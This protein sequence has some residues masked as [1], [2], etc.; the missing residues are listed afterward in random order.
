MFG[1]PLSFASVLLYSCFLM[2]GSIVP[3]FQ[4][5]IPAETLPN[6]MLGTASG[7]ILGVSEL[8]GGSAWP[9]AA[10]VIASRGGIAYAI[11]VAGIA[12][13]VAAVISLFVKE[14]RGMKDEVQNITV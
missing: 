8:T 3:F 6:Y 11:L 13:I 9:L 7:L 5:I 12:A 4:A 1:A 2:T 14:T 10:G